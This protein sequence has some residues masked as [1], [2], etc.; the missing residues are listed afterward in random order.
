MFWVLIYT[1]FPKTRVIEDYRYIDAGTDFVTINIPL[2]LNPWNFE[3]ILVLFT[4]FLSL[5]Q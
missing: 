2:L 4:I 3:C 1:E 5:S